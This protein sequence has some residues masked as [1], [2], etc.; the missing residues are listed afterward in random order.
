M[1]N[2]RPL[3]LWAVDKNGNA[4][5]ANDAV[6]GETYFCPDCE[7]PV[8]VTHRGDKKFF[9]C[10]PNKPHTGELCKKGKN[11]HRDP[12]VTKPD[13][14]FA[15]LFKPG[16]TSPSKGGHGPAGEPVEGVFAC[17]S[18]EHFYKAGF[19][20]HPPKDGMIGEH[21]LEDF[22]ITSYNASVIMN[23]NAPLSG[24]MIFAQLDGYDK[25]Q[26]ALR[27]VVVAGGAIK[28]KKIFL[29]VF[30]KEFEEDFKTLRYEL[31]FAPYSSSIKEVLIAAD[32]LDASLP[33]CEMVCDK[34][35]PDPKWECTGM[36]VGRYVNKR[37]IYI[38]KPQKKSK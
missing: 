33:M 38:P 37:Q 8:H 1:K 18:L 11:I 20:I 14:F 35:C 2:I 7:I 19:H 27:F 29:L 32:W 25:E 16:K 21:R 30:G 4:V 22:M 9:A 15:G 24:R 26:N 12:A 6:R 36:Q 3:A 34:R 17:T 13:D 10:Y 28:Q 5:H 23:G 31:C